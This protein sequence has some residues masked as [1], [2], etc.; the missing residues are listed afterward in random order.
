MPAGN[1]L[2]E[3]PDAVRTVVR[4]VP[5]TEIQRREELAQL[6]GGKT[7]PE[8][9]AFAESLLKK[10]ATLRQALS[11]AATSPEPAT[12]KATATSQAKSTKSRASRKNSSP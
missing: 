5:L 11:L 12:L 10:A 9:I 8:A 2:K 1:T 7:D 6:A 3:E 4:V